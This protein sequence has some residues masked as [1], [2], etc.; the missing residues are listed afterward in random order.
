MSMSKSINPGAFN[1]G[2]VDRWAAGNGLPTL[3]KK[4][5]KPKR[6]LFHGNSIPVGYNAAYPTGNAGAW[7]NSPISAMKRA[8]IGAGY[9]VQDE[10]FEGTMGYT[11]AASFASFD[12]RLTIGAGWDFNGIIAANY[13]VLRNS[14][15]QNSCT[16]T[17]TTPVDSATLIFRS[18]ALVG[19]AQATL[20]AI[21]KTLDIP[22][23]YGFYRIDFAPSDG[24]VLGN[25]ALQWNRRASGGTVDLAAVYCWNSR[26][27]SFQLLNASASGARAQHI[28][29]AQDA[30]RSLYFPE[31]VLSAGDEAWWMTV[32]NDW[33]A[34]ALPP[35]NDF[36][37]YAEAWVQRR[38]DNGII[39]RIIVDPRTA[40]TGGTATVT[41]MDAY[42]ATLQEVAAAKGAKYYEMKDRWGEYAD[43]AA[44]GLMVG[45]TD[46]FHPNWYGAQDMGQFLA[47]IA[48]SA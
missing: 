40:L 30:G 18:H 17:P 9:Q 5:V 16:F 20:G 43:A 26:L 42:T 47:Q 32:A 2:A 39:P 13:G 21:T 29:N 38:L 8:L 28:A 35:M 33:R 10:F 23:T 4:S 22:A 3:G 37:G 34:N 36:R 14:T 25:N 45:G 6:I 7:A 44:A 31:L 27:P 15:T 48:L 1:R 24:V 46:Y 12:T 11:T 41:D 19:L